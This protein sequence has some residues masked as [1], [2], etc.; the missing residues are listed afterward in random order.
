MVSADSKGMNKAVIS[1]QKTGTCMGCFCNAYVFSLLFFTSETPQ[2]Y[3]KSTAD[4]ILAL[5][6]QNLQS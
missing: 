6:E 2:C 4:W 1:V 5:G 3:F